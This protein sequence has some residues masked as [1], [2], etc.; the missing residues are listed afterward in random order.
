MSESI[1]R[2]FDLLSSS[3]TSTTISSSS[4]SKTVQHVVGVVRLAHVPG[5]DVTLRAMFSEKA[6]PL[7]VVDNE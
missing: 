1:R 2:V 7:L 4:N 6:M 3:S 5:I